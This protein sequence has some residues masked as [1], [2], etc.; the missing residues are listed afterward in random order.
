M[1][2]ADQWMQI[3]QELDPDW[4][5]VRLAFAPEGSPAEAGAVLA[6]L[7]PVRVRDELRFH[8][9]RAG[10]GP[11]RVRNILR[12]LDSKRVWGTLEPV[13]VTSRAAPTVAAP[14]TQP[15]QPLAIQW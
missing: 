10:G 15:S 7:Q 14:S 4:A 12:R 8:V 11:E 9:T 1:R 5:E 6:P 3:E 13:D 2:A